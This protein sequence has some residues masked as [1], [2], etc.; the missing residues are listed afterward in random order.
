MQNDTL[1]SKMLVIFS[2]VFAAHFF[3]LMAK[4]HK[5]NRVLGETWIEVAASLSDK[6]GSAAFNQ[7]M[8]HQ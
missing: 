3:F 4:P 7:I 2:K 1:F 6:G 5:H 8:P